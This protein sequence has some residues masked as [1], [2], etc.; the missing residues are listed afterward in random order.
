MGRN[1]IL[2]SGDGPEVEVVYFLDLVDGVEVLEELV[3]FDGFGSGFHDDLDALFEHGDGGEDDDDGE[4]VGAD[5]VNQVSLAP[6]EVDQ[7]GSNYH[8]Q[9]GQDVANHMQ[10]STLHVYIPMRVSLSMLV[11]LIM[12]I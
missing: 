3:C 8:S 9:R 2:V 1:R 12:S 4:D 6:E 5:G 7:E 10:V 11:S